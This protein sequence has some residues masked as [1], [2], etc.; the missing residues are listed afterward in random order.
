[1]WCIPRNCIMYKVLYMQLV[2]VTFSAP[3][4]TIYVI[5]LHYSKEDGQLSHVHAHH[6]C[7]MRQFN[8][9]SAGWNAGHVA[10]SLIV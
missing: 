3:V 6:S 9:I 10:A 8:V 1:M 7:Y 4:N 5:H 2:P